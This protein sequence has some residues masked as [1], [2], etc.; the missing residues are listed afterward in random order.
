MAFVIG[1]DCIACG[2]CADAC[3]AGAISMG[4]EHYEIDQDKCLSCG[5]CVDT[6]PTGAISEKQNVE[7][8]IQRACCN[9]FVLR[10]ALWFL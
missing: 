8:Y 9:A 1:S 2:A 5:A 4:D 7:P 3:P 6:C 10:Q